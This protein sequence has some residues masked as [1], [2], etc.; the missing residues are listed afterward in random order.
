MAEPHNAD[1]VLIDRIQ[2]LRD[3][4][5]DCRYHT[6]GEPVMVGDVVYAMACEARYLGGHRRLVVHL[7]VDR[8][9]CSILVGTDRPDDMY[10]FEDLAVHYDQRQIQDLYGM[11]DN[12]AVE[13]LMPLSEA[14]HFLSDNAEE[15]DADFA[16]EDDRLRKELR[17]VADQFHHAAWKRIERPRDKG[18]GR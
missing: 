14:L 9:A 13:P 4:G 11:I 15:L 17:E 5:W 8:G 16:P 6:N 10:P 3:A 18:L 1:P 7:N 12:E 2:Y